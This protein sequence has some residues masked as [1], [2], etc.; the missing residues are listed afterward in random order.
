MPV[1]FSVIVPTTGGRI[2]NLDLVLCSLAN[3]WFPRDAWELIVV[4]DA[5]EPEVKDLVSS[6]RGQFGK[7]IYIYSPKFVP[8][9]LPQISPAPI[10]ITITVWG[11][12]G[13]LIKIIPNE[14]PRNKGARQA[15]GDFYIFA[16][17]DVILSPSA[18][19]LYN[20]D[21]S[22]NP[23]RIVLGIYHWLHPMKITKEDIVN[24]FDDIIHH[25]IE[26]VPLN[27][28]QTHNICRDMRIR[29]FEETMP[30]E[31]H[32]K[33]GH[34]NDALACFS[35]NICWP[36]DLFWGI[37][38]YDNHLRA[39]AHEDGLSGLEAYFKGYAI[40]FD[41]RI[42]GGHLYHSRDVSYIESFKWEEI[43]YIDSRFE[44]ESEFR[45]TLEQS[46]EEMRRLGIEGWKKEW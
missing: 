27:R 5:G 15:E 3:Q 35:G 9:P 28:P 13:E 1:K 32:Q 36:K 34:M 4:N 38:G 30:N 41:K 44:K 40:S 18:L 19:A 21:M 25:Q 20:Q 26:K 16:D 8:I 42:V 10:E 46:E 7:I 39:G 29:A 6:Y 12:G 11:E 2:Q 37:E 24:R 14:Q 31:I 23:N 33:P 45:G 22:D 43:K 17:S